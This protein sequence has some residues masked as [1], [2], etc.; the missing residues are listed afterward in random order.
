[1]RDV[2]VLQRELARLELRLDVFDEM[3][4]RLLRVRVVCVAGHGDVTARRLLVQRG[5]EFAPVE[6]PAFQPGGGPGLCGTRRQLVEQRR[7]LRPVAKIKILRNE[8]TRLVRGQ[9]SKRQ[10]I[11]AR[12][13]AKIAAGKKNFTRSQFSLKNNS[14]ETPLF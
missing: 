3:Q 14:H 11:H 7:D 1:M 12:S 8:R 9:F 10:Q 5:V 13:L 6:Q 2:N 4:I